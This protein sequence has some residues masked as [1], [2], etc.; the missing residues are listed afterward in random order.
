MI[1]LLDESG[2][3]KHV[4]SSISG[5]VEVGSDRTRLRT[6]GLRRVLELR[7]W[8]GCHEVESEM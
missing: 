2:L 3:Q 8:C 4:R 6:R 1:N 7:N 5:V